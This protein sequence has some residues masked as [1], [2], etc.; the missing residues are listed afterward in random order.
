M[1]NSLSTQKLYFGVAYY[2]EHWK[3]E[4]W[5]HDV[6]L[7]QEAGINVV[8]MAEF[9]W[10]TMEPSAGKFNFSWLDQ[11]IEK[12]A[13]AEIV[14][15]L[16]TPTAAP[17][18]WLVEKHPGILAVDESGRRVQFGNRCHYCVNSP[19]FH[20]ASLRIVQA[21][22]EHFGSN[23]NVIGW[24]IDNE[25]NRVCYCDQCRSLFQGFLADK[26]GSLEELNQ[27]WTTAYWSQ[28]YSAWEQIPLPIGPHHPSLML[29]FKHFITASYR[30]F[31]RLQLEALRPY[32]R[33]GV[34]TTHNFMGWFGGYDHYEMAADLDQASWDWYVGTGHH[35]YLTSGA[36]HDLTRGFKRRNFWLMETQPGH[37]NWHAKNNSLNKGEARAMAW[38]AIAHGAD[39]LLYWQWRSALG[40]Q[41]QYHGSL[42]D[43]SGQ[44]RPFYEDAQALGKQIQSISDLLGG[45]K[46][47]ARVAMLNSYDSRLSIEFQRHQSDFDYVAHVNHYYRALAVNNIGVDIISADETLDG[48]KLVIAPA[49]I[50]LNDRRV[51]NLT[52]FVQKGGH[53]VL[54]IRTGMKDEYNALLPSRQPG[55]LSTLSGVEVEDYYA[56]DEPVSIEGK[57]LNGFTKQWA[58]R[59]KLLDQQGAIPISKYGKSNGWLD[60]QVAMV[61]HAYGAGLVYTVGAYLDEEAQQAFM[62]HVLQ[63][64]GIRSVKSEKDVEVLTRID[65]AGRV[66]LIVINHAAAERGFVL[67]WPALEHLTGKTVQN[68]LKLLPYDVAILTKAD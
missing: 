6:R 11:A 50:I 35:D 54:T 21:M 15:V 52:N 20:D 46:I 55:L 48:Y 29:E 7:M 4:Q 53:L 27:H 67:P 56:L 23:P 66:I 24:Q 39:G 3:E 40:G 37:V 44:P 34:W 17:P 63:M 9:A 43:P 18:A 33:T 31:Q 41:E 65:P 14:S 5:T 28:T 1:N 25:Y 47:N 51:T 58:E 49:L 36:V 32:Q 22:G 16:G 62:D 8:R 57:W 45:S 30:K 64:A 38:H 12:L 19:E 68:D 26:Y 59:L 13:A 10:S 2:P 61:A 60:G 42:L